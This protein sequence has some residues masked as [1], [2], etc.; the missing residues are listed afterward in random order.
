MDAAVAGLVPEGGAFVGHVRLLAEDAEAVGEAGGDPE[1]ELVFFGELDGGPLAEGGG[2][3]ADVDGYVEDAAAGAADDLSLRLLEL[4]V[5]A[6]DDALSRERVV[7]L[8]ELGGQAE[9]GEDRGVE[10][11]QEEAAVVAEDPRLNDLYGRESRREQLQQARI[12][13]VSARSTRPPRRG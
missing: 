12:L 2:A 1:H 4:V 7:V 13:H 11:L 5:Q 8:H 3:A 10:G 9:V 6:A